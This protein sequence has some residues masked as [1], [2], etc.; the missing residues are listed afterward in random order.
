MVNEYKR[1]LKNYRTYYL[2]AIIILGE[3]FN[4]SMNINDYTSPIELY[5]M[6]LGF[7][8]QKGL[9]ILVYLLLI[10]MV[11]DLFNKNIVLLRY[12]NIN[13]WVKDYFFNSLLVAALLVIAINIIPLACIAFIGTLNFGQVIVFV[14]YII[15][16][17]ATF[18]ILSFVYVSVFRLINNKTATFLLVFMLIYIP[19][20]ISDVLRRGYTT[21]VD[22]MFLNYNTTI[23][24]MLIKTNIMIVIAGIVLFLVY[25]EGT[26]KKQQD[27]IWSE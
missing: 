20:F 22:F 14:M 19:K 18:V 1:I 4:I 6:I 2:L 3:I 25:A 24:D 8:Y 11:M 17:F 15:N 10:G 27:I 5:Y 16:E 9:V 13:L 23:R 7:F 21:L 26:N 12:K